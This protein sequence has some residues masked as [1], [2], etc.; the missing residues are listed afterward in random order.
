MSH[1]TVLWLEALATKAGLGVV[2]FNF[3][4][5][6]LGKSMPDRMPALVKAYR[7]VVQSVRERIAP[8]T[9]ILG[10]HSMGGRVASHVLAENPGEADGLVLF[11]YPLHPAGKPEKLRVEH[12]ARIKVPT[13]QVNGT[14]DELCTPALME[15]ARQGLDPKLWR[16]RWIAEADHSY[17]VTKASGRTRAEV[18][19]EIAST[20]AEWMG[21][22]MK[23][24]P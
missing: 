5:R 13:L 7:A 14:K 15:A 16:L 10:G 19:D 6:V 4:Y 3:P 20:L 18:E 24:V 12:L 8:D 11:G 17:S 1:K 2:R 21:T 9:L 23:R 22:A